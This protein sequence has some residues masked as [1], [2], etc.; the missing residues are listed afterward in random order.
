MKMKMNT[1]RKSPPLCREGL[2]SSASRGRN[3]PPTT[4]LALG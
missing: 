3:T 2:T 4:C 1:S